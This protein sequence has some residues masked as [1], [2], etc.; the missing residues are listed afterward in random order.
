MT[1]TG[2]GARPTTTTRPSAFSSRKACWCIPLVASGPPTMATANGMQVVDVTADELRGRGFIDHR[3]SARRGRLFDQTLVSISGTE[4]VIVDLADRDRPAQVASLTIAWPVQEALPYGNSL[5]QLESGDSYVYDPNQS[6]RTARL[7]IAPKSNRDVLDAD[8]DLGV[9]GEIAGATIL[10]DTL[11]AILRSTEQRLVAGRRGS[12]VGMV[13]AADDAGRRFG[14]RWRTARPGRCAQPLSTE[15]LGLGAPRC[16]LAVRRAAALGPFARGKLVVRVHALPDRARWRGHG[17]RASI[18]PAHSGG[19]VVGA[20][21][22]SWSMWPTTRTRGS[23]RARRSSPTAKRHTGIPAAHSSRRTTVC[24]RRG[25]RGGRKERSGWKNR[26]C[27]KL[28]CPTPPRP[29]AARRQPFPAT[30]R[31]SPHGCRRL[32]AFHFADRSHSRS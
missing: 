9:A 20:K 8:V 32:R 22:F 30:G 7:R 6:P 12:T 19:G 17:C 2:R 18:S 3:F 23:L 1:V 29:A 15:P 11:Y 10:G 28:I 5:V 13:V 27:R 4:L 24:S 25:P 21:I 16:A 14:T 26:S 31:D